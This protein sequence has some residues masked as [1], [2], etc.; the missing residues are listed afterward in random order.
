MAYQ[1]LVLDNIPRLTCCHLLHFLSSHTKQIAFSLCVMLF[2]KYMLAC[3][4]AFFHFFFLS[5][6]SPPIPTNF[7]FLTSPQFCPH[8]FLGQH[9]VNGNG[10]SKMKTSQSELCI[11]PPISLL[12]FFFFF[13]CL[14]PLIIPIHILFSQLNTLS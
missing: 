13:L 12:P 8:P 3:F 9:F 11:L 10:T 4:F 6:L 14:W 1:Y 5:F 7:F 2:N